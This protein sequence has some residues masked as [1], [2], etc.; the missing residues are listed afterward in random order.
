MKTAGKSLVLVLLGAGLAAFLFANPFDWSALAPLQRLVGGAPATAG[1]PDARLYTCGMH[2]Q[3]IHEGPGTCPICQMDLTPL[4]DAGGARSQPAAEE[5]VCPKHSDT[6]REDEAG[7]CPICG[8]ALVLEG[9]EGHGHSADGWWTCPMHPQIVQD[10]PGSCPICGMDLVWKEPEPAPAPPARGVRGTVVTID[11]GV[12]QNMN[13]RTTE[14]ERGDVVRQ[15]RTVGSFAYDQDRMVTV[16]TKFEGWIEKAHVSYV[17]EKV[18]RGQPLFEIYSRELVQTQ[19]ELLSARQYARRLAGAE[20][21]TRERAEGLVAAARQRLRYW[22]ITEEQVRR[23]E[24]SGELRRT[25]TITSPVSGIVMR[26]PSG[27]DGMAVRPGMEV[28][29]LA[30]VSTLWLETEIYEDQLAWID[31]GTPAEVTLDAYP[32]LELTGRVQFVDPE[33]TE[34]TRTVAVTL[35]IPNP[36][37]RLKVGMWANVQFETALAK[38]VVVVPSQA[39]LRTG[40]RNVVVV[41]LG[42]GRFEPREVKLGP[43]GEG[44]V[45]VRSGLEAGTEIVTSAQFLIDSESSLREAVQ[46][47]I[48]ER[49]KKG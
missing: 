5:W 31:V 29:H 25:L 30:D 42:G 47:M 22:D 19:Q 3:V 27:L 37:D 36:K 23:I 45:S 26:R 7:E 33:V 10:E 41:A 1:G 2:P 39:V 28:L 40:E 24:E 43:E 21:A 14:A 12:I 44:R 18:R 6:I 20:P 46:K 48:A 15:L 13:V 11:P 8:R 32:G 4:A 17:G 34:K 35:A 38:D 9:D 49:R 16:T